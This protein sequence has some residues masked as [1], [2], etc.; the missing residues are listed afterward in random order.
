MFEY[1][2]GTLVILFNNILWIYIPYF[3]NIISKVQH[4]LN[5]IWEGREEYIRIL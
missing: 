4:Y 5:I 3:C 2:L 1:I